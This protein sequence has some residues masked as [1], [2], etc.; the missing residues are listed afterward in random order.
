MKHGFYGNMHL[1][2]QKPNL[3]NL[4][5]QCVFELECLYSGKCG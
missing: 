5:E 1:E 4:L 3:Q 2:L